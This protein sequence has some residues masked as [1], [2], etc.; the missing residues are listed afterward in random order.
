MKEYFHFI[1]RHFVHKSIRIS[2]DL[3]SQT[4]NI[5]AFASSK[6][7][8]PSFADHNNFSG[9]RFSSNSTRNLISDLFYLTLLLGLYFDFSNISLA[10]ESTNCCKDTSLFSYTSEQF[11]ILS[12]HQLDPVI[13]CQFPNKI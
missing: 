4:D 7:T 13:H 11:A 5:I 1:N 2:F 9:T 10:F 8:P 6:S 3:L 12:N